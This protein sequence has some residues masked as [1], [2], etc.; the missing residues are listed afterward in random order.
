MKY[1][2]KANRPDCEERDVAWAD[3]EAEAKEFC[4]T[5]NKKSL[6]YWKKRKFNHPNTTD[7]WCVLTNS[8]ATTYSYVEVEE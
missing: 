2:I 4:K 6:T 7:P 5:A 3:T 1:L 8:A